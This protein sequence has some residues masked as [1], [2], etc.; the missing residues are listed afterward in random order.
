MT[1]TIKVDVAVV[2]A[3]IAGLWL[4]NRLR[5]AGYSAVLLE[6]NHIGGGQTI[7]SQ[8][9]IHGGLKY[10][11]AGS[12]SGESEAIKAMPNIWKQCLA[13]PGEIDLS[14]T[15]ILSEDFYL[16][17]A[18]GLGGKL[19]SFFASK[20]LRGRVENLD[21]KAFP[22]PFAGNPYKGRIYRLVDVVLDMPSLL[23]T[24]AAPHRDYIIHTPNPRWEHDGQ[25]LH[26]VTSDDVRIEAQRFV[27]T[28]GEGAGEL[29]ESLGLSQPSMQLRP[30]QQVLVKHALPYD[31]YGHCIGAQTSASPRLTIST[32][33]CADGKRVWYLG[34]D[35]ATEG[36]EQS[37]AELIKRAKGELAAIFPWLDFSDAQWASLYIN[38]AEPAQAQ[39]LKP[40]NAFA[41]LAKPLD[42]VIVGWP[43]KLTLAPDLTRR[44]MAQL[45]EL[46]AGP[47]LGL[48]KL[49][50][51]PKPDIAPPPWE[52]LF[53]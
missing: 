37:A 8:G 14:A 44:V 49:A 18:G 27:I 12:L 45:G 15:R 39:L 23:D 26:A 21:K 10:A 43:T 6:K 47:T 35:L 20:A 53:T 46:Q 13:G 24:L 38:R 7:A 11:L 22:P 3:G 52:T 9:M 32:H 50:T 25:Q 16:W 34:G 33:H 1:H 36:V 17:S 29:L 31:L 2:G 28:A 19:V 5:Q 30:L 51:L 41:E 40:D 4:L 42:N 48:D